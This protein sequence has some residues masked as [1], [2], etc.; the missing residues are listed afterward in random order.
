MPDLA[1]KTEVGHGPGWAVI[2]QDGSMTTN[3]A[4]QKELLK[5]GAVVEEQCMNDWTPQEF[6]IPAEELVPVLHCTTSP[7]MGTTHGPPQDI[8]QMTDGVCKD[9]DYLGDPTLDSATLARPQAKPNLPTKKDNFYMTLAHWGEC[10]WHGNDEDIPE[11][12]YD[13][14]GPEDVKKG[15]AFMW[16]VHEEADGADS[17]SEAFR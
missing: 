17:R 4:L 16:S 1:L 7:V 9:E 11:D 3:H 8:Y 5:G 6:V 13:C 14:C 10:H 2:H 15:R 12:C